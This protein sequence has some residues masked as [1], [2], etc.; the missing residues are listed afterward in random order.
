MQ[1]RK[2][3]KSG[4][5][6]PRSRKKITK[7]RIR[8]WALGYLGRFAATEAH[9]V[10]VLERKIK[11]HLD[12]EA[13]EADLSTWMDVVHQTARDMVDL[14]IVNDRLYAEARVRSLH[15]QGKS[16][17]AIVQNLTAKGVGGDDIDHALSELA[18]EIGQGISGEVLDLEAAVRLARR[19]RIGPF[20]RDE[21]ADER[22]MRREFGVMAR[23]GFGYGVARRVLDA[24][25][26][27]DLEDLLAEAQAEGAARVR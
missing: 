18:D 11:R 5:A 16:R 8:N 6:R 22:Q 27:Q 12:P 19:R 17:R 24:D 10:V 2:D 23:A 14:G 7:E 26:P 25:S 4:S 1:S 13:A 15:A 20:R 21:E 3:Y 9:L